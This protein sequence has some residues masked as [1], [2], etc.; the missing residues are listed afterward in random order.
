MVYSNS[1]SKLNKIKP[2]E[3]LNDV[4]LIVFLYPY[5]FP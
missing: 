1:G 4:K 2:D 5:I 3:M